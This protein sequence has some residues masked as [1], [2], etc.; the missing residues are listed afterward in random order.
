MLTDP[1]DK[2]NRGTADL[3]STIT[4]S[5]LRRVREYDQTAWERMVGLYYPMVYG[6][7]R[8]VGLQPNDSSDVCQEVFRGIASSIVNFHREQPGDTFRGWVRRITQR[9]IIDHRQRQQT[10]PDAVGGDA[11]QQRWL[12]LVDSLSDQ[13]SSLRGEPLLVRGVMD[14]VRNEFETKT[15]DAF[16]RTTVE[17]RPVA[18]VAKELEI[19]AN[20]VYLAKSRVLRRLREELV[21]PFERDS[22]SPEPG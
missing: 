21:D 7:C 2:S 8:Q 1:P 4:S 18:D 15:W 12:E 14:L 6:W 11:A 19:T 5:L 20:A 9:R 22:D 13:P 17:G 10:R 3:P 16:W